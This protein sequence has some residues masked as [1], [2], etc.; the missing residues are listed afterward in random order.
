MLGD[1]T[2]VKNFRKLLTLS[3]LMTF[4]KKRYLNL[5]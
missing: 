3:R 5:D 4:F 2:I 1:D